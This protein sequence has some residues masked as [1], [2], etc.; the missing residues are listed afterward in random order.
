M[1]SFMCVPYYTLFHACIHYFAKLKSV[2]C[3]HLQNFFS[4]NLLFLEG[5]VFVSQ[6]LL[7]P[8]CLFTVFF[9]SLSSFP[10]F[11]FFSVIGDEIGV[12]GKGGYS[13]KILTDLNGLLL[14]SAMIYAMN[15]IYN[16]KLRSDMKLTCY[17]GLPNGRIEVRKK[18]ELDKIS[19]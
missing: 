9:Y 13:I 17:A 2:L 10:F 19:Q 1:L 3:L 8:I 14:C 5:L 15:N 18:N 4:S 11:A 6:R 16:L 12:G 7:F